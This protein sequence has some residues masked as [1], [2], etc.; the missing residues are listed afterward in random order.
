MFV[1]PLFAVNAAVHAIQNATTIA[2][3]QSGLERGGQGRRR[4][5]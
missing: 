5:G 2:G 4:G 1:Q 3:G